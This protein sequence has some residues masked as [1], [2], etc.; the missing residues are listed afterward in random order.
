VLGGELGW[1]A[2]GD[3]ETY[4]PLMFRR[5]QSGVQGAHQ[6]SIRQLDLC[7]VHSTN[8]EFFQNDNYEDSEVEDNKETVVRV[9][10]NYKV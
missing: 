5:V 8:V 6:N 9:G 1:H 3:A 7:D 4:A 2:V 10:I